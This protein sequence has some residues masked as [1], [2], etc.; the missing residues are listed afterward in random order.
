MQ[1]GGG[2]N[3]STEKYEHTKQILAMMERS[4]PTERLNTPEL[5]TLIEDKILELDLRIR[6]NQPGRTSQIKLIQACWNYPDKNLWEILKQRSKESNTLSEVIDYAQNDQAMSKMTKSMSNIPST[7]F[8]SEG[9]S[10]YEEHINEGI[11]HKNTREKKDGQETPGHLKK[12]IRQA[13]GPDTKKAWQC[14][15]KKESINT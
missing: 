9:K 13:E 15:R 2:H 11:S 10:Y 4:D 3:C 12:M 7:I 5:A 6:K 14:Y 8:P 1:D